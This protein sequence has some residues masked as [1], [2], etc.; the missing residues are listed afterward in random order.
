MGNIKKKGKSNKKQINK[1]T[2]NPKDLKVRIP[3]ALS[4]LWDR[5]EVE[6]TNLTL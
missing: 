2:T 6:L 1:N 3:K 4:Q 5:L